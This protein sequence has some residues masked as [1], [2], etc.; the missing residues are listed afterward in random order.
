MNQ[1]VKTALVMI[2]LATYLV[3]PLKDQFL[4]G[5]HFFSHLASFEDPHHKHGHTDHGHDHNMIELIGHAM[6]DYQSDQQLPTSVINFK[7]QQPFPSETFKLPQLFV[8]VIYNYFEPFDIL[9]LTGPY[10]GIP[11]PPP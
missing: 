1:T 5:I 9:A 7:F 4:T 11:T 10:Y 6:D 8:S 2:L 3:V